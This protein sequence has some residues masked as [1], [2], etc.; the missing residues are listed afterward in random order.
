MTNRLLFFCALLM[1]LLAPLVRGGNRQVALAALLGLG[2]IVIA[3]ALAEAVA[4]WTR[5][6]DGSS[7][8]WKER[9]F[10]AV[11][12]VVAL[13]P[14][15]LAAIQLWPLAANTWASMPG[16]AAYLPALQSLGVVPPP[17]LPLSLSPLATSAS[18]W[19]GVPLVAAMLSGLLILPRQVPWVFGALLMAVGIQVLISLVQYAQG[20]GSFWYFD[21]DYPGSFIGTFNNRNHLANLLV[22]SIPA[23]FALLAFW[24][25]DEP[26][27]E[28]RA[29]GFVMPLWYLFGFAVVVLLMATQ[30]RGGLLAS[31]VALLLSML[32]YLKGPERQL[33]WPNWL[34][35]LL[36]VP[37]FLAVGVLVVGEDRV[38]ER[39]AVATLRTDAEFRGQLA[40]SAFEAAAVFWPWGSGAG[41]FEAV[42]PK[43]QKVDTP[44]FTAYAHNDYAQ[45]LMEFGAPGVA[46]AVVLLT[47]VAMRATWLF[48]DRLRYGRWC[49]AEL[50]Q[51]F[52]GVSV[53]ALMLHS[54]V[55][56]NLHIPALAITAALLLGI[57]LRP[58]EARRRRW[59]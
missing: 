5:P 31:G 3:V 58:K 35:L 17:A 15:W 7:A 33:N 13:S 37:I 27:G 36:L 10:W 44:G 42:F 49:G 41:T 51:V 52:S 20:P 50:Q 21:T 8:R 1:L 16:R 57:Y 6:V 45:W 43:F 53:L 40:A 59:P 2:L 23:W 38:T 28:E 30:S 11:V 25:A 55:E 4:S 47:L 46:L 39:F 24:R 12:A 34:G 48:I 54:W 19:A 9:S 14:A 29:P 22:L 32:V 26:G 56:F 18:L